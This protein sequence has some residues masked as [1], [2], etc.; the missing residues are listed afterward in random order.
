MKLFYFKIKTTKSRHFGGYLAPPFGIQKDDPYVYNANTSIQKIP[1]QWLIK[2]LEEIPK[3]AMRSLAASPK[4]PF[5]VNSPNP[6][7]LI[8]KLSQNEKKMHPQA[9]QK[10]HQRSRQQQIH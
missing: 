3:M 5:V 1:P 8:E 9:N 7:P 10:L 6:I 2:L 4:N